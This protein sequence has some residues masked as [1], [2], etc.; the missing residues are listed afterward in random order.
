M[1]VRRLEATA[2]F[3][4]VLAIVHVVLVP[5]VLRVA[6][7]TSVYNTTLG[8]VREF[9]R[10]EQRQDSWRPMSRA[11]TYLGEHQPTN[12]YDGLFF[13]GVVKFQYPLSSLWFVRG[14]SFPR[15]NVLSWITVVL[16]C[17]LVTI[18][19]VRGARL[20]P[21]LE[22]SIMSTLV[23][24]AATFGLALTFYP[25]V[26]GY[27]LGQIQTYLDAMAAL[28]VWAWI[29]GRMSI[30][31]AALGAMCLIKPTWVLLIGWAA[32]R[33]EW[34]LV[35]VSLAVVVAG[36][37]WTTWAFGLSEQMAYLR[38]LGFLSRHG[39][40]YYANQSFNG[41]INRALFNG[42]NLQWDRAAF[43]PFHPVVYAGTLA[44][45]AVLAA[46]A[47]I[48]P[49]RRG[50]ARTPLDLSA[51]IVTITMTSP[52]AWE[53][54]YGA[55]LPAYAVIVWLSRRGI[56]RRIAVA[57]AASYFLCGEYLDFVK[58]FA[59]TRANV[60]QSYVLAG[61][62]ILLWALYALMGE[63]RAPA[64]PPLPLRD[65]VVG[66]RPSRA[67][68]RHA[69]ALPHLARPHAHVQSVRRAMAISRAA[70]S[71]ALSPRSLYS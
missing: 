59:A 54:H 21:R 56:S 37:V 29:G 69:E 26:K 58:A 7:G 39:E 45:F 36:L 40:S 41:L 71:S 28:V 46:A 67:G 31:G 15:L 55:L 5:V 65:E 3:L 60:L 42:P 44:A 1:T 2:R 35:R 50:A 19:A 48:L 64:Q 6:A 13:E 27:T 4:A 17:M 25:L 22:R 57:A 70:V 30:A 10:G 63:Q 62:L 33:R 11:L 20:E 8:D 47:A 32:A 43:P 51:A 18:I 9:V 52:I 38:V 49:V 53:H 34:R 24:G 68:E 61:G 16:T 12:V 66:D 23:L 14:L